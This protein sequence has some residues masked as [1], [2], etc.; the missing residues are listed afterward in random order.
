MAESAL[1][2]AQH[3]LAVLPLHTIDP[4]TERCSCDTDCHS[5]GKH[6]VASLAPHGVKDATHDPILIEQWWALWPDANI[7]IACGQ[8]S[9]VIVVDIDDPAAWE[10]LCNHYGDVPDTWEVRTGSGGIHYYFQH[11]PNIPNSV[12]PVSGLDIR[13]DN[14]YVVAPPSM[15]ISGE[16]YKWLKGQSPFSMDHPEPMPDWIARMV[17][18]TNRPGSG[19]RPLPEKIGEGERNDWMTSAAGA[20]RRKNFSLQAVEAALLIENRLRCNPPLD[21]REVQR[22]ARSVDRY[23]AEAV[24]TEKR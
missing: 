1:R 10:R 8:I 14:G 7:G 16:T 9:D 12:R 2:L 17:G 18:A 11:V 6:P 3:G 20:M 21:D 4:Y 5:P 24:L 15:H 22:I 23:P 13:S 19:I